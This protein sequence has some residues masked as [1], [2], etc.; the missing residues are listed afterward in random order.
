MNLGISTEHLLFVLTCDIMCTDGPYRFIAFE[1]G[2]S[3]MRLII[4]LAVLAGVAIVGSIQLLPY[5]P[6][7][8]VTSTTYMHSESQWVDRT[9]KSD[10]LD[11]GHIGHRSS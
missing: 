2:E 9:H 3:E 7:P 5:P 8:T 6:A 4:A 11:I 10:R 1:T